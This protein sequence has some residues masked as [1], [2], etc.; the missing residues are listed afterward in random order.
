[1]DD[2]PIWL[3]LLIWLVMAATVGYAGS[4]IVYSWVIG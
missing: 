1:M 4:M 3:K 2:F